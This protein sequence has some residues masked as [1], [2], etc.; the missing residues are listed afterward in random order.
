MAES[1]IHSFQIELGDIYATDPN[2]S[3]IADQPTQISLRKIMYNQQ[4]RFEKFI[5]RGLEG[6]PALNVELINFLSTNIHDDSPK[7]VQ[8][9]ENNPTDISDQNLAAW[10]YYIA[11][12]IMRKVFSSEDFEKCVRDLNT[13]NIEDLLEFLRIVFPYETDFRSNIQE[14]KRSFP[15]HLKFWSLTWETEAEK[16]Q[17]FVYGGVRRQRQENPFFIPSGKV[18]SA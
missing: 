2:R 8:T 18:K 13:D 15:S 10:G 16:L 7:A 1:R 11:L 5:R 6:L 12:P 9:I 4:Q 17:G 14:V 3:V